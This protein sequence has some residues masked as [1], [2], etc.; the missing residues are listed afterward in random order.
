MTNA[1]LAIA[2]N[3]I[4]TWAGPGIMETNDNML[5]IGIGNYVGSAMSTGGWSVSAESIAEIRLAAGGTMG[6][7]VETVSVV[8]NVVTEIGKPCEG[9]AMWGIQQGDTFIPGHEYNCPEKDLPRDTK[10]ETTEVVEVRTLRFRWDGQD[11][12][13]EHRRVL[14]SKVRRWVKRDEW[15]EE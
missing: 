12:V 10:R 3:V 7:P 2:T 15:R 13:V 1:L 11:E 4:M 14:E 8:T 5:L 9:C 6:A